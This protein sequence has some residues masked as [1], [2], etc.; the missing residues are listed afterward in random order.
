MT[1]FSYTKLLDAYKLHLLGESSYI[2][3]FSENQPAKSL[4]NFLYYVIKNFGVS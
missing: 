4:L 3:V 1:H 2:P